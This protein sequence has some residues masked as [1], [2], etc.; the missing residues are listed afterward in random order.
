MSFQVPKKETVS[1]RYL[2]VKSLFYV[3][4]MNWV[5]SFHWP[6]YE[7]TNGASQRKERE[8]RREIEALREND[9]ERGQ[10]DDLR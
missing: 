6:C 8:L 4:A 9:F 7:I 1:C 2:Q 10:L 5:W 3:I